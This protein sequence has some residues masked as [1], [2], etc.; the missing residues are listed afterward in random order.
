MKSTFR[1]NQDD[2]VINFLSRRFPL[3]KDCNWLD[4]NCYYMA[5]IL[6]MRFPAGDIFYDVIDGHFLFNLSNKFYDFRGLVEIAESDMDHMI[7]WSKFD[8][9]DPIQRKQIEQDCII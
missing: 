3:D 9:Y 4:G 1:T 7:E 2:K 8:M 6:K 5:K